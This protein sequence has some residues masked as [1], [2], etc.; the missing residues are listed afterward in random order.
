MRR[1]LSAGRSISKPAQLDGLGRRDVDRLLILLAHR[2]MQPAALP[3]L[4]VNGGVSGAGQII[5]Q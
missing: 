1:S 4:I 3:S 5:G 2:Q